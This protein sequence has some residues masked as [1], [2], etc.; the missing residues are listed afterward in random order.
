VLDAAGLSLF[1]GTG[2]NKARRPSD[3]VRGV[4][5]GTFRD[6]LI[7]RVPLLRT[8]FGLNAPMPRAATEPDAQPD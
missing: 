6:V 2:A 5:G 4:V 3:A 7:R 1:A 8:G